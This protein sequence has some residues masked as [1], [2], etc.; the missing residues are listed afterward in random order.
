MS[1]RSTKRTESRGRAVNGARGIRSG[2]LFV[3]AVAA[4]SVA[5][6]PTRAIAQG[7]PPYALDVP[8]EIVSNGRS[9]TRRV[10]LDRERQ[11]VTLTS[12]AQPERVRLDP[13]LRLWRVLE[14]REL[15]PILREWILARRPRLVV[16]SQDAGF[17]AAAERL[18]GVFFESAAGPASLADVRS[19]DTPVLIVGAHKDVDAALRS[20]NLPARGAAVPD[21][22]SAQ[23]WTVRDRAAGRIAVISAQDADAVSAL[24]RP[25]P[26]YG[27]QSY[28]V[29]DG[30]RAIAR[31]VW[32]LDAQA[33]PVVMG[34]SRR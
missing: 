1:S 4:L 26:H 8:V 9:E 14:Q 17:R 23:V 20:L 30:S 18:A 10:I 28:L 24:A 7:T 12:A 21:Q 13:E 34:A 5:F 6:V 27:A 2:R 29:F 19:S 16:V 15:P 3:A 11:S 25:L 32:P 31:G 22:G 33:I